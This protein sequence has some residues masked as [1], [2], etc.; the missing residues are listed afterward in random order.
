MQLQVFYQVL[1]LALLMALGFLLR[2]KFFPADFFQH[3]NSLVATVTLPCLAFAKLQVPLTRELFSPLALIFLLGFLLFIPS[4]AFGYFLFKKEP[5][6]RRRVFTHLVSFSNSAFIGFPILSAAFGEAA[7]IYGVVYVAAFNILSWTAG[8]FIYGGK[9]ALSA[10]NLLLNP[11]LIASF[12]GLG[13]F[14]FSIM[15]PPFPLAAITMV[16]DTTTPLSMLVIGAQLVGLSLPSLKDKNLFIACAARLVLIPLA[17]YLVFK[18]LPLPYMVFETLFIILAM[19]CAAVSVI[20][21]QQYKAN[22]SL[23]AKG[24]AL[25]TLLSLITIP[26]MMVLL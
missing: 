6:D 26:L 22:Q 3:L 16:G 23:A 1:N 2:K 7:L 24:V 12:L 13:F 19:P 5:E 20:Q 14:V 9:K 4:A 18:W 8:V 21:A 10:K 11:T 25:S 15:L 17:F